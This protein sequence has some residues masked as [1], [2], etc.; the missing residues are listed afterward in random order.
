MMW[1]L[2]SAKVSV[3]FSL[4]F[5]EEV[6]YLLFSGVAAHTYLPPSVWCGWD[7]QEGKFSRRRQPAQLP[8]QAVSS[9][10]VICILSLVLFYSVPEGYASSLERLPFSYHH[11]NKDVCIWRQS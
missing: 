10:W 1:T 4:W 2:I 3:C 6:L 9:P 7:L 8:H 5:V 11:W